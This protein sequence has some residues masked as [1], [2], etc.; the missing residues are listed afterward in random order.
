MH[1]LDNI[2]D[3]FNIYFIKIKNIDK[4]INDYIEWFQSNL[5]IHKSNKFVK[6]TYTRHGNIHDGYCS[7]PKDII[8]FDDEVTYKYEFPFGVDRVPESFF[9]KKY[10]KCE[11]GSGYCE[12]GIEYII[13][14]VNYL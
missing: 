5:L 14:N 3:K 9:I 12:T 13:K 10:R 11:M 1:K 4:C 8:N 6:V 7:D 2:Q